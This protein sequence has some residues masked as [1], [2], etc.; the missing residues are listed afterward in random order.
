[1]KKIILIILLCFSC[2][3]NN[4]SPTS[5]TDNSAKEGH[6]FVKDTILVKR[7]IVGS[8]NYNEKLKKIAFDKTNAP[9]NLISFVCDGVESPNFYL[10]FEKSNKA[11]ISQDICGDFNVVSLQVINASNKIVDKLIIE[12]EWYEP[13]NENEYFK[14]ETFSIDDKF[15]IKVKEEII[16]YGEITQA[17]ISKYTITKSGEISKQ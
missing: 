2:K 15:N 11:I 8:N 7:E 14:K 16:E 9:I 6:E 5:S 12:S 1:M 17:N 10:L 4:E 3:T 13:G